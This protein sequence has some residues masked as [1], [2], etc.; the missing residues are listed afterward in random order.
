MSEMGVNNIGDFNENFIRLYTGVD[1]EK[2]IREIIEKRELEEDRL[3]KLE[4]DRL[5]E[6]EEAERQILAKEKAEAEKKATEKTDKET[7]RLEKLKAAEAENCAYIFDPKLEN[8]EYLLNLSKREYK[9]MFHPDKAPGCKTLSTI[10][11]KF[12][13]NLRKDNTLPMFKEKQEDEGIQISEFLKLDKTEQNYKQYTE[14]YEESYK[15]YLNELKNPEIVEGEVK[16][17][18]LET[19]RKAIEKSKAK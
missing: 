15:I 10:N 2:K 9:T 6:L 12:A 19:I 18:A 3:R 7:Q 17:Y 4:E 13:Q 14:I 16:E 5:R 11:F 1:E 8:I